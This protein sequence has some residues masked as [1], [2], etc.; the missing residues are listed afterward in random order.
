[1]YIDLYRLLTT[2]TSSTTT[3]ATSLLKAD[4]EYEK[5]VSFQSFLELDVKEQK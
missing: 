3:T 2:T 4:R 1:M 5:N